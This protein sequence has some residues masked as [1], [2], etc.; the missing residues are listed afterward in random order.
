MVK[1]FL[2][3]F[4]LLTTNILFGQLNSVEYK[5]R[6][7]SNNRIDNRDILS[8]FNRYDISV[9]LTERPDDLVLG[10][11]GDNYQRLRIRLISVI[12]NKEN[13]VQYFVYGKSMVKENVCEF[14]GTLTLTN[15][16]YFKQS[17]L[18]DIKQG[19]VLGEYSFYENPSQKHVGQFKGIFKT[20]WYIDKNGNLRFDDI[21]DGAD[22]YS[23][24]GFVGTWT[25]YSG[26][27]T[28]ICNWGEQRI[29]MSGD[30]DTG[31][32]EFMPDKKYKSNGW[33]TLYNRHFGKEEERKAGEKNER[34]EWW[35]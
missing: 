32:A 25:S 23:N 19:L 2:I 7:L 18:P 30:L 3:L 35:K 34:R 13:P 12:K 21:M 17:E 24:N 27:I 29:P 28:K 33:L 20:N 4:F 22:G 31:T 1:S 15:A 11:I 26:T 5:N 9:L 8:D 14:Q 10:F 16:F 6:V